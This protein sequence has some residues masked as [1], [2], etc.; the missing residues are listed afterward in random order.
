L[1]TLRRLL[2]TPAG[3]AAGVAL[4]LA[5]VAAA[6]FALRGTLADGDAVAASRDRLFICAKTGKTFEHQL[7]P[8]DRVP[9]ESP[10][11]GERTGYQAELCYWTAAGPAKDEPTPVLLNEFAGRSGATFCPDCNRLVVGHNPRPDSGRTAPPTQT[12]Y[13]QARKDTRNE[14]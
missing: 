10:H 2:N 13:A 12:E 9:V 7:R 14:R 5:F 1:E 6:V 11:S 8:G 4:S 3:R